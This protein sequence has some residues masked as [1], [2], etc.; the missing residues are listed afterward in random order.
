MRPLGI[1]DWMSRGDLVYE[2]W[3]PKDITLTPRGLKL[4]K[5][6]LEV[7]DGSLP[8][9]YTTPPEQQGH[10]QGVGPT[11]APEATYNHAGVLIGGN[12]RAE[13]REDKVRWATT[14][15]ELEGFQWRGPRTV[16]DPDPPTYRVANIRRENGV[17]YAVVTTSEHDT[18]YDRDLVDVRRRRYRQEVADQ[19]GGVLP[20][21][22]QWR[23][24]S[25][26]RLTIDYSILRENAAAYRGIQRLACPS[27]DMNDCMGISQTSEDAS[28]CCVSGGSLPV[29]IWR[30]WSQ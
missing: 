9:P 14:L 7:L 11:P 1:F 18:Q 24:L 27:S 3:K 4:T 12:E 21:M 26:S 17:M 6:S 10:K 16:E 28:L 25:E 30:H 19:V 13:T 2:E 29:V 8:L 5:D 15:Q 20:L 23:K 22:L